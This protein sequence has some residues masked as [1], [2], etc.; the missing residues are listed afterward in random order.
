MVIAALLLASTFS[1]HAME[2][3]NSYSADFRKSLLAKK[4]ELDVD[5]H[6]CDEDT[7]NVVRSCVVPERPVLENHSYYQPLYLK[8]VENKYAQDATVNKMHIQYLQSIKA[9]EKMRNEGR[10]ENYE[11]FA[12]QGLTEED[13]KEATEEELAELAVLIA[14][15][16]EKHE[17]EVARLKTHQAKIE[18]IF[19]DVVNTLNQERN[20]ARDTWFHKLNVLFCKIPQ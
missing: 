15:E 2:E 16:K 14:E 1:A 3:E 12:P 9:Q 20:A 10:L 5:K 13:L 6:K 4:A 18:T 11:K 19:Q 7:W 17:A 8:A